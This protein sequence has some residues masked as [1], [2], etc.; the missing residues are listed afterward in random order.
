[1]AQEAERIEIV[2]FEEGYPPFYMA[3]LQEGMM[4]DFLN[5]FVRQSSQFSLVYTGLSRKRIDLEM[6]N[7]T[8][9]ASGLT[10]PMFVGAEQAD[11]FLFSA[12]IWTSGNYIMMNKDRQFAYA[13]PE[14]LFG[15]KLGV[16]FG[17]RNGALDA[18]LDTGKIIA[19]P[20]R[21][22]DLLY[23]NLE[24]GR[25]DAII[26]NKHVA[27]YEIKRRGLDA[28]QFIFA[29][30]PLFEFELMTQAQKTQQ[31]F[32]EQLNAFIE[33]SRQNGLLDDLFKKYTE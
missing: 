12:P 25:V 1:M 17:N 18:Y 22:N 4:I 27:L 15:K 20:A 33:Q 14:D 28:S 5:A 6:M 7:G 26:A 21:T 8:A 2:F 31:A 16:I 24:M 23:K 11:K 9:Q 32:I 30:P 13:R 3:G 29:E 19:V 10:N